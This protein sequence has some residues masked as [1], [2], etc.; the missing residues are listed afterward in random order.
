MVAA[1]LGRY[2]MPEE[3]VMR[4]LLYAAV[5]A[6]IAALPAMSRDDVE[7]QTCEV[8]ASRGADAPSNPPPVQR[9]IVSN[10]R[11]GSLRA[12]NNVRKTPFWPS[13]V[14]RR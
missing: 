4:Q 12:P 9:G 7:M 3:S 1:L 8:C 10:S 6:V 5:I 14:S 11:R 2:V 13:P